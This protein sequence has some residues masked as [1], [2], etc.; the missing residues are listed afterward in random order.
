MRRRRI[1]GGEQT[2]AACVFPQQQCQG[3]VVTGVVGKRT[4]QARRHRLGQRDQPLHRQ[5]V[6]RHLGADEFRLYSLIWGRFV[7]S[8][9]ASAIFDMTRADITAGPYTFRATGS[10][11][12]SPGWLA[13]YHEGKDEDKQ[14]KDDDE[15]DDAEE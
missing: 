15:A 6:R 4:Q 2:Q 7:A 8:Q 11:L 5:A 1:A 14:R 3:G 12:R 10:V 13:V 9:M